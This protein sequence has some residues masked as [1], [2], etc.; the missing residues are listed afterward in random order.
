MPPSNLGQHNGMPAAFFDLDK[1]VIAR[2]SMLA[3]SRS[4]FTEGLINRR[5]VLKSAYAQFL[6]MLP[7]SDAEQIERMREQITSLCSG[8]DVGQVRA[9]VEEAL[10]D[11][12]EP[13]IYAEATAL[14]A[15]HRAAGRDV[16]IV[17]ASGQELVTPIAE[18]L[19]VQRAV[20][21]EMVVANGR[22]TGEIGFYCY[23]EGKVE[24]IE[25]LAAEHDYDLTESYAYTDSVTDLPM[26]SAV[27]RPHAVNPDKSLRKLAV[28]Y[29]WPVL[30]FTDAVAL[31]SMLPRPSG[32]MLAAALGLG[33]AAAGATWYGT[34]R[35][36]RT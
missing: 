16:V 18:M 1:T 35:R 13:L 21:T 3:F 15:E 24:A 36:H 12:V 30:E 6:L 26:L 14:I 29:G 9:V 23:G 25:K 5:A 22:Y 20:G 11:V 10:H 7:G 2:S 32:T 8:W 34:R 33:A 17:S 28:H 31:H 19:G 27:G 4:F